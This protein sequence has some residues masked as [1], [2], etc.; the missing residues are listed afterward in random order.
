MIALGMLLLPVVALAVGG[1][2]TE[3]PPALIGCFSGCDNSV[4]SIFERAIRWL[5][6][7]F[8]ILAVGF[9]LWAAFIYLQAGGDTTQVE[10][11]KARLK[12]AVIAIVIAL[13]ATGVSSIIRTFINPSS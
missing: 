9:I 7:A 1:G 2:G 13:L 3:D 12:N 4:I 11:A 5:Y 6:Q 8:F 10:K